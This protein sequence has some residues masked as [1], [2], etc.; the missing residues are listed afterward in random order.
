M[1]F[2]NMIGNFERNGGQS[3]AVRRNAVHDGRVVYAAGTR[4]AQINRHTGPVRSNCE[5]STDFSVRSC[6]LSRHFLLCIDVN[7][8]EIKFWLHIN[9]IIC[10]YGGKVVD[11]LKGIKMFGDL[12]ALLYQINDSVAPVAF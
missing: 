4:S 7:V 8:D 6:F 2:I 9:T 10:K 1:T 5:Q 11:I 12:E 3:H